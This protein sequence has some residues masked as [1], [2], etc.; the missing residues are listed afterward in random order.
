MSRRYVEVALPPPLARQLT[1]GVPA[2]LVDVVVTGS[3]VLVP[4]QQRL[5]TGFVVGDAAAGDLAPQR[6]RDLTQVVDTESPI[7][8]EVVRLCAWM[9]D[10]YLAPMGSALSAALPPGVRLTSNRLVSLARSPAAIPEGAVDARIC[11]ELASAGEALKVTTLRKRLGK[12][13]LEAALRRL[14]RQGLVDLRPD[15]SSAAV[16]TKHQQT[17]HVVDEAAARASLEELTR[18]APGQ[19]RCLEELLAHGPVPKRRLVEEGFSYAV[20]KG[21]EGRG[22]VRSAEEEVLR[23]PLADLDAGEAPDLTPTADQQRVLE[24]IDAALDAAPGPEASTP[25]LLRGVTGSGKTLV[26]MVAVE[27][28]LAAGGSA[29]VLTPEIALAWQMVRRFR[30]RFGEQVAVL[31]SQLSL[32]ERY[33]TWRRLRRG[34]QRL[35]IGARSAVFAPVRDLGLLI[36]DE[37]H[38]GSYFQDDLESRQPLVYNGRDLAVVRAR[39]AGVPVVLG[40]ATPSLE[41]WANARS[42]KYVLAELPNRVDDRPLARVEVVD[43]RREPFQRK[44]RTLFSKSLRLKI[45]DR[46]EKGE[47]VV[48]LQNRRGFA[49]VVQCSDC[50]ES[51]ECRRCHVTLTY[52]RHRG[53]ELRCHYCDFRLPLPERCPTCHSD[54]VR[55]A[56]VGTQKVEAALEE[57]FPGIR[58]LR[59]DVDTTGWKGA[60]DDIVERFRRHEADVLLGTQMVAKGLDFPEV[61]LVGVIS[62]DTGL[63]MPDFRAAERSFQLLTQVAGRSGRGTTAGEVVIQT[64]QPEEPVL[65]SAA[66]QD[67]DAF[68]EAELADRRAGGF[69]PYGRL[70]VLRWRGADEAAVT[71]VAATGARHL[72]RVRQGDVAVLGPAPAP[73]ARLRGNFRWQTLLV[74]PSASDLRRTAA[75]ALPD[76]RTAAARHEVDVAVVVDPQSTM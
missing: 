27:R 34:E 24:R 13:G 54:G 7:S 50:G 73:L 42:G 56:G 44:E 63:H 11:V 49:P 69:P 39:F 35:V 70:V 61:T 33:D 25:I 52:H 64:R 65:Q 16:S 71:R 5:V 1:Y 4:V 68:S 28:V 40:S 60:H 59:M 3:V 67:Y 58:V 72:Q 22:L 74:G 20:L 32:G 8:P 17:V 37:E 30:A 10:Y 66:R 21:L 53:E 2:D 14:Q 31:H 12:E 47:Q 9:A 6:I 26:Y 15:L 48:L 41:S 51:V 38:D 75:A 62:A 55:L 29:I 57:Q 46:L 23:D 36:V 18:R 45:H 76:L 19:A 43:M